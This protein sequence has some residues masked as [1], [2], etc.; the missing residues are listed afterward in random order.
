MP[1][2]TAIGFALFDSAIGRCGIAWSERG[3]VAG[4]LRERSESAPRTRLTARWPQAREASPP[5][6]VQRA[7]DAMSALLRGEAIE[8][9][10]VVL[11]LDR[12]EPFE[13]SVYEI[14]RTIMPGSTLTY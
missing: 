12:I 3:I 2:M 5:P 4:Q 14:A 10:D 9:S 1:G 6:Q 7:I 8:L 13:R 11:D